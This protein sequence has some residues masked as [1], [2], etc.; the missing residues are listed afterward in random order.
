[1]RLTSIETRVYFHPILYDFCHKT[2]TFFEKLARY[3]LDT[4]KNFAFKISS[5]YLLKPL[6][7]TRAES[8]PLIDAFKQFIHQ[9]PPQTLQIQEDEL[10]DLIENL[11]P[12]Q[13]GFKFSGPNLLEK[14]S[15]LG[16]GFQKKLD[17]D[18]LTLFEQLKRDYKRFPVQ[19][20]RPDGVI[21]SMG[22]HRPDLE[23]KEDITSLK[24]EIS[25]YLHTEKI[26]EPLIETALNCINQTT[27]Y[28][29]VRTLAYFTDLKKLLLAQNKS[30]FKLK[31]DSPTSIDLEAFI[32]FKL[33][34][35]KT[36][37]L[38]QEAPVSITMKFFIRASKRQAYISN[39]KYIFQ[40]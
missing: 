6:K 20:L 3:I 28:D 8:A 22:Q 24:N 21:V 2:R 5:F 29:A 9:L 32:D 14:A 30:Y 39:V 27:L 23:F 15:S 1:M 34:D 17:V 10:L 25:R 33:K 12:D 11:F 31:I 38:S 16:S 37:S 18:G 19:F 4:A 26:N 35:Q 13:K 36:L 40:K 7:L